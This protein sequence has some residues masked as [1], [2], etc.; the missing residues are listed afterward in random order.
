MST[1][2]DR[3]KAASRRAF[4]K[5]T[6]LSTTG[7]VIVPRHVLGGRGFVAPS[8][9]VNIAAVGVGGRGKENVTELLKLNDVQVT[10]IA[11]PAW[12]WDLAA[13]YYR[14]T[15]GR[16]PVREMVEKHYA[17]TTPNYKVAEYEDFRVMLEKETALD[18]ILCATPDHTH[19][20]VSLYGMRAGKHVYCEKPLTHNLWEARM[21]QKVAKETGLA[22]QMGNQ[23][24][25]TPMV[26][27]AVEYLRAGVIG[28][29]RE[30]HSWVP[31]TRWDKSLTGMPD[32]TNPVPSGLNWDLWLGPRDSRPFNKAY[33][34]VTWRDFWEF[35]CGALGDFGCHDMDAATWG[36]NL[37]APETVEVLPA[38]YS[39]ANITPYGEIGYYQFPV[40]GGDP[41]IKLTWY[42]GGLR[43]A[44]PEMAP[45]G[46]TFSRRGAMYVGDRGIMVTGGS[47]VPKV[48]PDDLYASSSNPATT[49]A[50]TNGHHR[51]WVDAIKGGPAASSNFEYGAH[52]T[53]ITLLGVLSLRLG[54]QKIYWDSTN[55]KAKGL[56]DADQYIREPERSGW[57]MG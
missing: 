46:F 11:D 1:K 21:V 14:T 50:P 29:V 42:S 24:H 54:G 25:S 33:V 48:F 38:G 39:D 31:A 32:E 44:L 7:F 45:E 9:K 30:V 2:N 26:R 43:P 47:P 35:G 49:L 18:A 6:A 34:P 51:D 56:D 15:A 53:E 8:D 5:N 17:A 13:F 36:L 37:P 28:K 52:L 4:L 20:Y 19:A 55:L 3:H 40:Q 23:M 16:G 12:Y 57:E 10:A 22:T 41:P 27:N